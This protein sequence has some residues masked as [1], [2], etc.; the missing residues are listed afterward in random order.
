V[1]SGVSWPSSRHPWSSASACR[2]TFR[3]TPGGLDR[4][5]REDDCQLGHE[6]AILVAMSSAEHLPLA[7]GAKRPLSAIDSKTNNWAAW[8][9]LVDPPIRCAMAAPRS[10]WRG[11]FDPA[12]PP[13]HTLGR[14]R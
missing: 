14:A 7:E 4:M 8:A 12:L 2:R 6:V 13:G 1:P 3:E 11:A 10:T 5:N 9:R